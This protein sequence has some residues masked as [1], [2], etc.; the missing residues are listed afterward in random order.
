MITV[1]PS[2]TV[3][4]LKEEALSALTSDVNQVEDVPKI[5]S[6][7]DFEICRAIKDKGKITGGYEIMDVGKTGQRICIEQ[8]GNTLFAIS[9]SFW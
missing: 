1:P 5:S 9:E 4:E 2:T 3:A 7:D 6:E 8:L